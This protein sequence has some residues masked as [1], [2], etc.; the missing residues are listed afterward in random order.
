MIMVIVPKGRG[1]WARVTLVVQT[2]DLLLEV[3]RQEVRV[4]DPLFFVGRWWRIV[5]LTG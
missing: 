3:R 1:N 4:G 2:P 5:E